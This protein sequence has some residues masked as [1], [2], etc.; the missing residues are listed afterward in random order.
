MA[1]ETITL[2]K[3]DGTQITRTE[4]V[5]AAR[6]STKSGTLG[7]VSIPV[8]QLIQELGALA[9]W[10]WVMQVTSSAS[11]AQIVTL[12]MMYVTARYSKTPL[13]HSGV[14]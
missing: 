4:P 13:E 12:V 9:P 5:I 6:S 10:P 7:L 3:E 14:L 1:G 11:F 2:T 8:L